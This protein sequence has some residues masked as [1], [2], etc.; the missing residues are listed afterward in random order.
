MQLSRTVTCLALVLIAAALYGCSDGGTVTVYF[1]NDCYPKDDTGARI[2][3]LK[4]WTGGKVEWVN[5]RT[6][7]VKLVF[8][9]ASIFGASAIT[10]NAGET[11]TTNVECGAGLDATFEL[12]CGEGPSTGPRVVVEDPP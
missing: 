2:D 5:Q 3:E 4:V 6:D 1:D 12:N 10:V 8:D 11:K 9:D 7:V